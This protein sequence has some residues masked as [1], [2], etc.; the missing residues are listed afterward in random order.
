MQYLCFICVGCC[1]LTG[2]AGLIWCLVWFILAADSPAN[3]P[4]ISAAERSYIETSIAS[5]QS[6]DVSCISM[7]IYT[8]IFAVPEILL[9]HVCD[10][11]CLWP[12][13]FDDS[14]RLIM[15][16]GFLYA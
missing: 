6:D 16:I 9:S 12:S 7:R 3:H 15:P 13:L 8:L 2:C 1:L 14:V 11:C 5:S 10:W 4:R